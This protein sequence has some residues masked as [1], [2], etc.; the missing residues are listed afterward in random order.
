MRR[1]EPSA[2]LGVAHRADPASGAVRP[3]GTHLAAIKDGYQ[4]DHALRHPER[5]DRVL[6]IMSLAYWLLLGI[7]LTARKQYP[8]TMGGRELPS[9]NYYP[10]EM[11]CSNHRPP[12]SITGP[13]WGGATITSCEVLPAQH[14][15]AQPSPYGL[16]AIFHWP[17]NGSTFAT[18][19]LP[20]SY[21][22][23]ACDF[24]RSQK[25]GISQIAPS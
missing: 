8:P 13:A 18:D 12:G 11:R 17:E 22:L 15:M 25:L 6:L 2:R 3:L 10:A 16:C 14:G 4:Q 23:T 7:G 5:F 19:G 20:S 24:R 9:M 1:K 21:C